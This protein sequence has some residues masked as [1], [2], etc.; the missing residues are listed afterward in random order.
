MRPRGEDAA[1]GRELACQLYVARFYAPGYFAVPMDQ[2]HS[3]YAIIRSLH[4]SPMA[5]DLLPVGERR[6]DP[7]A[8]R[9][10]GVNRTADELIRCAG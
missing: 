1:E 4:L 10:L 3:P 6:D 9:V 8:T 2:D 5:F 7:R